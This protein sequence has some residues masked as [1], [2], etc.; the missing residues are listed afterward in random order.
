[1]G[2]GGKH[3][4]QFRQWRETSRRGIEQQPAD[5]F[6]SRSAARLPRHHHGQ[7]LRA[8][9][10]RQFFHLGTLAA[11]VESLESDEPAAVGVGGHAEMIN[12]PLAFRT[13]QVAI[14]GSGRV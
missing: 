3:E 7:S 12:D 2:A 4:G 8:Q 1:L 10:A 14:S 9:D 13:W 11:P 6:P 5:F